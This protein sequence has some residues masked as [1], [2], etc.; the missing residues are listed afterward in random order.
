LTVV[1][2]TCSIFNV[3]CG[4]SDAQQLCTRNGE[5]GGGCVFN[6]CS[7]WE[8]QHDNVHVNASYVLNQLY[9]VPKSIRNGLEYIAYRTRITT[10]AFQGGKK[11]SAT[12]IAA[13]TSQSTR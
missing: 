4:P 12:L 5:G 8:L 9:H 1:H 3:K 6:V 7:A 13:C 2:V 11:Q 10:V